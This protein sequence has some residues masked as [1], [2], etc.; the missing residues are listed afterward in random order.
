MI[1]P[2][3]RLFAQDFTKALRVIIDNKGSINVTTHA[4]D[5][6]GN[7]QQKG[8]LAASL[9]SKP[10]DL[11]LG[12]GTNAA[13]GLMVVT[14]DSWTKAWGGGRSISLGKTEPYPAGQL[15]YPG[16]Y[17]P[18]EFSV[19]LHQGSFRK[20][21]G[22]KASLELKTAKYDPAKPAKI[23]AAG[24]VTTSWK[25]DGQLPLLIAVIW[26]E[27]LQPGVARF[28]NW[29]ATNRPESLAI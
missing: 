19:P 3:A 7:W 1:K 16:G 28:K 15:D 17:D 23:V 4:L 18:N 14:A 21:P 11:D 22:G 2:P 6:Q 20:L 29:P 10:L 5:D 25:L 26:L 8:S 24:G 13:R 12:V 9:T 27:A